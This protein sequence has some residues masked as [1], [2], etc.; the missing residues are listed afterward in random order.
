MD[1]LNVFGIGTAMVG[2]AGVGIATQACREVLAMP[3]VGRSVADWP[4][5]VAMIFIL[6]VDLVIVG[7]GAVIALV[8]F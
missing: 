3:R 7:L 2:L 5:L 6:A 1:P 8:R 4:V